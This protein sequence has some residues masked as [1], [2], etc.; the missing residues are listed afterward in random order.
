[1]EI[2]FEVILRQRERALQQHRDLTSQLPNPSYDV[3]RASVAYGWR[4]TT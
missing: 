1:M 4:T 2:S 3:Q